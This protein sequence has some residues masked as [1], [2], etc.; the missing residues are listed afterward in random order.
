MIRVAALLLLAAPAFAQ[1]QVPAPEF[2]VTSAM[3]TSTAQILAVNCPTLSVD[4][5]AMSAET[6]GVLERLERAGFTPENLVTRMED[7]AD[8][9]AVLQDA[10]LAK[11]DL[12]DGA[13]VD[14]VCGAG[15][16][17]I[18]EGSVIG[19]LLLEVEG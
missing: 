3:A 13:D 16:R 9:I 10:F 5:G 19:A 1:E 4:P 17:E 11:H 12:A 15:L 6:S 14:A 2:F 7:P 18:S 8:R